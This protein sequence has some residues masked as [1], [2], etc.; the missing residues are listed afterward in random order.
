MGESDA[1][2][3]AHDAAQTLR[4]EMQRILLDTNEG[5]RCI[6]LLRENRRLAREFSLGHPAMTP[7]VEFLREDE[8]LLVRLADA[9]IVELERAA[10]ANAN[11]LRAKLDAIY[12]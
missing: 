11:A 8:R 9:L 2:A 10:P 3:A 5:E 6:R 7:L 12:R 4:T 1:F